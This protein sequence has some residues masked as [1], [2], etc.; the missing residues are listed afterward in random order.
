[1]AKLF[2][3]GD[4]RHRVVIKR[5]TK[6]TGASGHR[7]D[8]WRTVKSVYAAKYPLIGRELYTALTAD[9]KIEVKYKIRYMSEIDNTMRIYHDKNI[10]EIIDAVDVNGLH[11]EM[12]CYCRL[13]K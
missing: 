8:K 12:I 1:M 11:K 2:N 4:L 7:N 3:A 6:K 9:V 10:Y 5:Q 13:V